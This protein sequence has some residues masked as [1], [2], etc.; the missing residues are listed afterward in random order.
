MPAR[1]MV[2]TSWLVLAGIR[3]RLEE[4]PCPTNPLALPRAG[5]CLIADTNPSRPGRG[6]ITVQPPL[7]SSDTAFIAP[8][9]RGPPRFLGLSI[10][11]PSLQSFSK[12]IRIS[13]F[14]HSSSF[15]IGTLDES[16]NKDLIL[17]VINR[18]RA[19][20]NQL[21]P[22]Q[23]GV[24]RRILLLPPSLSASDPRY[25]HPRQRPVTLRSNPPRKHICRGERVL[26]IEELPRFRA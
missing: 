20:C 17:I 7:S 13:F 4:W 5:G 22:L 18:K 10:S 8:S 1:W 24:P 21:V 25:P 14:R 26:G 9:N 11:S 19:G 12:S 3:K 6:S 23:G 2:C 15:R 16:R